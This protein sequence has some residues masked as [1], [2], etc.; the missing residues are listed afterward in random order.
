MIKKICLILAIAATAVSCLPPS[1][2]T[3]SGMVIASFEYNINYKDVFGSDSLYFDT[4]AKIGFY[5][6][7][8]GFNHKVNNDTKE[9]EGGFM[10]SYLTYP[11]S[12]DVNSMPDNKYRVNAKSGPF[13][14]NTYLVFEQT[15]NMPE[16]HIEFHLNKLQ[17]VTGSCVMNYCCVNNT[18]AVAKAVE[19][20]FVVGDKMLL[21]ARGYLE[22]KPT[23]TAEILLAEKST[24]KDS[25]MYT[26]TAFDLSQLGSIDKV[27][28]EIVMPEGRNV[29]A[30]VCID[31]VVTS[32]T[33]MYQ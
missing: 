30:T 32:M 22:G 6:D 33:L 26:W 3:E 1:T 17:G 23:G 7:L 2:R 5:W 31:E 21:K 24:S 13:R 18:V 12:I 15:A 16:N 10:M 11:S 25:I 8:L 20:N 4:E 27:N 28:F 9:F 19:E 29:P 14:L